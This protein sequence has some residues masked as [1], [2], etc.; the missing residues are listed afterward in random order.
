MPLRHGAR[1]GRRPRALAG[2]PIDPARPVGIA[3]QIWRLCRR[4]PRLSAVVA[5]ALSLLLTSALG[6]AGWTRARQQAARLSDEVHR[7]D[8]LIR[9]RQYVQDIKHASQ[10]WADNRPGQSLNLLERY[11]PAP[12]EEDF[13]GF[14]WHYLHR[15][16]D[17]GQ[18]TLAG[19]QGEVYY[20]AFSPHGKTVATAG[21]DKTVRLWDLE[22]RTTRLTLV[23]HE[24]EINWVAFSPDGRRWQ[25]PVM[26]IKSN[27]GT[28]KRAG[29]SPL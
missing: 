19:H 10:L 6:F 25:P 4:N 18:E 5:A 29:S 24:D 14:A 21:Q 1:S 9:S 11:R 23:G 7:N 17:V 8:H 27:S 15:L 26:T 3:E 16:C 22:T 20:V 2:R 28:S 13:R 12:N